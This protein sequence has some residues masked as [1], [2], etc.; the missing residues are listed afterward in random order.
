MT[1]RKI[2]GPLSL[3]HMPRSSI[4]VNDVLC[5]VES[6]HPWTVKDWE[7]DNLVEFNLESLPRSVAVAR[8][9]TVLKSY[10]SGKMY[11]V[12]NDGRIAMSPSVVI[13]SYVDRWTKD[14]GSK[15]TLSEW[16][17]FLKQTIVT[18]EKCIANIA[19]KKRKSRGAGK[20]REKV[21][22]VAHEG[23]D[24]Y[25]INNTSDEDDEDD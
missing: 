22:K 8:R 6:I 24:P 2:K 7:S 23:Y 11:A 9:N 12:L 25:D 13:Q 16:M 21:A 4:N 3:S 5:E 15:M 1:L 18:K 17:V 19:K 20:G 14:R 10:R